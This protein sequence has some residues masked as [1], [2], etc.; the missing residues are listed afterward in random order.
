MGTEDD[1]KAEL[2]RLKAENAVLRARCDRG[3]SMRVS[4]KGGAEVV[5]LSVTDG[6]RLVRHVLSLGDRAEIL[7]PPSLRQR[8]RRELTALWRRT[9]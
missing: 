9:R 6:E 2:D 7:A 8:A 5:E 3:L 1:L 4:E